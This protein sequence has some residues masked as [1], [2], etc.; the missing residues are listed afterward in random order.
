[1]QQQT[2]PITA[3]F[4]NETQLDVMITAAKRQQFTEINEPQPIP[5]ANQL[6]PPTD[7]YDVTRG[8]PHSAL[9]D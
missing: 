8:V 1:M 5:I 2:K 3:V 9:H 7:S 4:G 6:V